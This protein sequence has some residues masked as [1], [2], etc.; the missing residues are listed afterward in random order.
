[1]NAEREA[2]FAA[3]RAYVRGLEAIREARKLGLPARLRLRHALERAR[4]ELMKS[5]ESRAATIRA[6]LRHHALGAGK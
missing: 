3:E 6:L 1:M 5:T 4:P 2:A